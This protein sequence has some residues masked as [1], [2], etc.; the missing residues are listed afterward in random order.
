MQVRQRESDNF[1][2]SSYNSDG[3]FGA[4]SVK[5]YLQ[6]QLP[7]AK[8]VFE[9]LMNNAPQATLVGTVAVSLSCTPE[10]A[11]PVAVI[12]AAASL[13]GFF[14]TLKKNLE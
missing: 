14:C 1:Q 8:Q 9:F 2:F 11:I 4:K 13:V 6:E 12:G 5:V 3:I 7:T 10:R